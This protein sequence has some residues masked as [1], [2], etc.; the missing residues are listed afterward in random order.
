[1]MRKKICRSI[2]ILKSHPLSS[3]RFRA[4]VASRGEFDC[5]AKKT[6]RFATNREMVLKVHNVQ[7]SRSKLFRKSPLIKSIS[8]RR[9]GNPVFANTP[10][11][12][13]QTNP[14]TTLLHAYPPH[15]PEPY[16]THSRPPSARPA[17]SP[18]H[19]C[20]P[21]TPCFPPPPPPPP[22]R[23]VGGLLC[24]R[25]GRRRGLS[26]PFHVWPDAA[27]KTSMGGSPTWS[28]AVAVGARPPPPGIRCGAIQI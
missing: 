22:E 17:C 5:F 1:M 23:V 13:L 10:E 26:F 4:Y 20:H 19:Y 18:P 27:A 7:E 6:L 24:S 11:T 21:L 3:P 15:G 14:P 25:V 2:R 9:S 28:N 8:A 12:P 16:L